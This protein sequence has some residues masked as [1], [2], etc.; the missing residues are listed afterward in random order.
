MDKQYVELTLE[1]VQTEAFEDIVYE[2]VEGWF[3]NDR[4]VFD[5][6]CDRVDDA[7]MHNNRFSTW[8][9]VKCLPSGDTDQPIYKHLR[10]IARRAKQEMQ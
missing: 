3:Q 6:L 10:K 8:E 9:V 7:V 5:D 4:M 1:E 2:V